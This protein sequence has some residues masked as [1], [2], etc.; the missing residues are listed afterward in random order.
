M[1][2]K[3]TIAQVNKL[4]KVIESSN[5]N[6]TTYLEIHQNL[7]KIQNKIRDIT[8]QTPA[9]IKETS[10]TIKIWT[11]GSCL[12]NPGPGGWAYVLE[13][14]EAILEYYG[15]EKETTNNQMEMLAAIKA[16]QSTPAGTN[17]ILHTDSDYLVQGITKWIHGW[18]KRKW[19]KADG[20]QVL[21]KNLW[22]LLD[23]EN[24]LR[25]VKWIWIKAHAGIPGNE[26]CDHLAKKAI[27][28]L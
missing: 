20:K 4:L 27:Q 1:N 7:I 14:D 11:D 23:K 19:K 18:K 10:E 13:S 25:K 16:L 8:Q 9:K 22:N 15:A 2:K 3:S 28:T 26:R 21:N 6:E 24:G 12:S 17:I 5:L